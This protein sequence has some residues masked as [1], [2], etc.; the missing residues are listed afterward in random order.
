M[1]KYIKN[2][3]RIEADRYCKNYRDDHGS[4]KGCRAYIPYC[5][6]NICYFVAKDALI[7]ARYNVADDGSVDDKDI[8]YWCK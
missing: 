5:T 4:C 3:T 2:F 6:S 7:K 1:L 8:P